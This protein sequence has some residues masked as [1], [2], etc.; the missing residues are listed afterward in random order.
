MDWKQHFISCMNMSTTYSNMFYCITEAF[1]TIYWP[2]TEHVYMHTY[3]PII[4]SCIEWRMLRLPYSDYGHIRLSQVIELSK[5]F[6]A[7]ATVWDTC[8][9]FQLLHCVGV[10]FPF[11]LNVPLPGFV[12]LH[13]W[14]CDGEQLLCW[15]QKNSQRRHKRER[16]SFKLYHF[17]FFFSF[18][19]RTRTTQQAT[20][21]MRQWCT[22]LVYSEYAD[23]RV[24]GNIAVAARHEICLFGPLDHARSSVLFVET[25]SM[26][27]F[28]VVFCFFFQS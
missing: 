3:V 16:K 5:L 12:S 27:C 10:T 15:C 17:F 20:D 22:S 8:P 26:F 7:F 19:K 21:V 1:E 25:Q 13:C 4:I 6:S 28:D 2:H 24:N 18:R 23:Y 11:P 9:V 14:A